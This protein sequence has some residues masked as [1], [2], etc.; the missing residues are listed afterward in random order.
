MLFLTFFNR[1]IWY[2]TIKILISS[3][4]ATP[5]HWDAKLLIGPWYNKILS[6]YFHL[7]MSRFWVSNINFALFQKMIIWGNQV[8]T[9][10]EIIMV[11]SR[12][13]YET[14]WCAASIM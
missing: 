6:W 2:L 13:Q 3:T 11:H 9:K 1:H 5:T 14:T 8:F 4:A 10:I 12:W 7:F